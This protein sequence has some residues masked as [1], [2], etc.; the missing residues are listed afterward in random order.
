MAKKPDGEDVLN[1][2]KGHPGKPVTVEAFT[3]PVKQ[4]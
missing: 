2:P 4:K 3:V 1:L